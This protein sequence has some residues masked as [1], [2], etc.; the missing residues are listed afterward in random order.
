ML[1]HVLGTKRVVLVAPEDTQ[2]VYPHTYCI[3][4]ALVD[5]V[6]PNLTAH[7][8]YANATLHGA[9][10]R[11]GDMLFIPRTWWHC[12]VPEGPSISINQFHGPSVTASEW[13]AIITRCGGK[14]WIAAIWQMATIGISRSPWR[15]PVL[16]SPPS[17]GAVLFDLLTG[18]KRVSRD[19]FGRP[20]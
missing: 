2:S 14:H 10:L 7:P 20:D 4:N 15:P 13:A 3:T 8:R 1:A 16:F 9:T 18:R 17:T 6:A 12:L 19:Y 5:P 11:P